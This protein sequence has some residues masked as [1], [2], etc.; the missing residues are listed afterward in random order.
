MKISY[1]IDSH[2]KIHSN[3][4]SVTEHKLPGQ[5]AINCATIQIRGRYPSSGRVINQDCNELAYI[6]S[7]S[8]EITI[9]GKKILLNIGDAILIE[10]GEEYFWDGHMDLFV[11]CT[12]AWYPE[13]HLH[14]ETEAN[15]FA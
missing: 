15:T 12:P 9:E 1:S 4:C 11:S 6:H 3:V 10:K 8:G 7:G 13:Q 5:T 2:T 14:I